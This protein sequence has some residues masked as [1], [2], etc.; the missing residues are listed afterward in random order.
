M[1]YPSILI[2]L[3]TAT[4]EHAEETAAPVVAQVTV[5]FSLADRVVE[6]W[7]AFLEWFGD[8]FEP[9]MIPIFTPINAVLQNL[10]MPW[11]RICAVGMFIGAILW[12]WFGMKKEYVHLGRPNKSLWTDLRI[13]TILSMI[14]HIFVYLYF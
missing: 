5:L 8:L 7:L 4:A 12:V 13:W 9:V 3:L 11:A 10:Y 6:G 2:P 1:N 14:P